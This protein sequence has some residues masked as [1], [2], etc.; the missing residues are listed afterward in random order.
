MSAVAVASGFVSE[1][2]S[3]TVPAPIGV[4]SGSR[5]RAPKA[6]W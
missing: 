4:R 3:K 2:R 6:A 5:L 1:E